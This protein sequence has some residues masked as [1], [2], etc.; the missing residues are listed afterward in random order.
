MGD[1]AQWNLCNS[2]YY[3]DKEEVL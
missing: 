2:A 3:G 1:R